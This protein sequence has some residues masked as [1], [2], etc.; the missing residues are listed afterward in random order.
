MATTAGGDL[1]NDFEYVSTLLGGFN[2]SQLPRSPRTQLPTIASP[3][4]GSARAG[5]FNF[6]D[7]LGRLQSITTASENPQIKVILCE[8]EARGGT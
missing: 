2:P 7:Y 6:L 1:T 4:L 5:N 8:N 3:R